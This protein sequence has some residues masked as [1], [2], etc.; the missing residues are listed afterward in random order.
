MA[1]NDVYRATDVRDF[2]VRCR[3]GTLW[4]T[5]PEVPGDTLVVAG[6]QLSV[7]SRGTILVVALA[8]SSIW[9]PQGFAVGDVQ[10]VSKLRM[11]LRRL[12]AVARWQQPNSHAH[13]RLCPQTPDAMQPAEEPM[14]VKQRTRA[15]SSGTAGGLRRVVERAIQR[16][17]GNLARRRPGCSPA[18][19][20]RYL[21]QSVDH[22]DFESRLQRWG[23]HEDRLRRLPPVL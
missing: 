7:T 10:E 3:E 14:T 18:A 5:S 12:R 17:L 16:V 9:I 20:E 6:E 1:P 21:S 8:H 15:V 22:A 19:R 23:L 11:G 2:P 4:V 13:G